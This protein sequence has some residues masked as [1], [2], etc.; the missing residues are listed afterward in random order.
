MS[1]QHHKYAKYGIVATLFAAIIGGAITLYIHF[2]SKG[3]KVDKT[4]STSESKNNIESA[5]ITIKEVQLTPVDFD[6][7]SSFYLEIENGPHY[8]AKNIS[9]VID[10]G[11]AKIEK[12]SIKP[13]DQSN[14]K[15]NGDE[16]IFKLKITELLKNESLYINCL[17]PLPVFKK[18]LVT[19][20]NVSIDKELTFA[21][22]KAQREETPTSGWYKFFSAL[23]ALFC[24]YLFLVI[25]RGIN[26]F[27]GLS[28]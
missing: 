27:L 11:E 28:W 21:S 14:I 9:V 6:I 10:F 2:D 3:L 22:F 13:N 12:C 5:S 20:G 19:G 1:E 24:I 16:Y 8:I 15:V 18:I 7:P 23:A 26:S 4:P 17:I 25:V